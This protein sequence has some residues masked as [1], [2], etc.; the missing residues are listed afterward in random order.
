MDLTLIEMS[1][2]NLGH[3]DI[4]L[5]DLFFIIGFHLIHLISNLLDLLLVMR[6]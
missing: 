4:Q 1:L 5:I 3:I 6:Y 2:F